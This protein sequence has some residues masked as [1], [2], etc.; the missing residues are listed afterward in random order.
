MPLRQIRHDSRNPFEIAA[1]LWLVV[2]SAFVVLDQFPGQIDA[3]TGPA[4]RWFWGGMLILGSIM[5][6]TGIAWRRESFG[7]T[8]ESGGMVFL[9]TSLTV[10]GFALLM[11]FKT[12][13]L[14]AAG[15]FIV[16]GLAAYV[17]AWMIRR[18]LKRVARGEL[19]R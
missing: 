10:Y 14:L 3:S 6:A 2:Y 8:L 17:R 1:V 12:S 18:D 4:W 7:L 11:P 5:S 9:G 15:F 19:T 13:S 16:F